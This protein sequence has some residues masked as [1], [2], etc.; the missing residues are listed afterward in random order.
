MG[1]TKVVKSEVITEK[2]KHSFFF[3]FPNK[4]NSLITYQGHVHAHYVYSYAAGQWE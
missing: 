3:F 4:K 2:N 1:Y